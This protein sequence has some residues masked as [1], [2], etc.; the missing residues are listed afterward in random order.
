MPS[1]SPSPMH[2]AATNGA[3]DGLVHGDDMTRPQTPAGAMALTEYSA[4]PSPPPT[5]DRA[6]TRMRELLPPD[7]LLADGYPD[8]LRLIAGATSRVY[9][10]CRVTELTRAVNLSSRLGCNVLLKREDTQPVFSFKLRGAYNKMA[11]LDPAVSWKGVVCCSAG[12][13][14][15]GVAYSARKLKIP[16]TII[17]P[18]GTPAIKHR[19]V[20][21]LGG[22]VVLHGA[23]FDAAK[24]ECARRAKQDGLINIPP[25]DDPY[26][27]AGQGTIG[28]E[29]FSQVNMAKVEAIFCCC[30]GG[31]LIA[32]VGLYVKRMAPHVKVIGVE[33]H[34]ANALVQ[35]LRKDQRVLLKE[36]GL[37]ADG[38]AVKTM[39]EETF[40]IARDVVDEVIEVTTD[41]ICAAIK[42]MYDDTR[43]GLEPA[44]AM[45]IAGLKKYVASH[46]SSSYD[47]DRSLIAVTSGANMD[48][49]RLRFVAE[50]ASLGEGKEVLLAVSIAERPGAFA[51]LVD[52]IMPHAVTEFSYRW[53]TGDSAN[54]LIGLSL[55]APTPRRDDELRTLLERIRLDG[56]RVLDVSKDELAKSHVR[57]LV[58][59]RANVPNE[60]LYMFSFPERPGALERFL[61]ALRPRFNISV[62]HYRNYGGDIAKVLAGISCPEDDSAELSRF[63]DEVGYPFDECT[64]SD[65]FN[66]FLRA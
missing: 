49:D 29:L 32:G 23:D 65:V 56:M 50:R 35:S 22:H 54:M 57:Y 28:N 14:A 63:L 58:G 26:V 48:F 20:S 33:A 5:S 44:G 13:H 6:K 37:F 55:T 39:G 1:L 8:Y 21:R 36:V 31:G 30:G 24:E 45:S 11:H 17:M 7:L 62:F 66:M 52:A 19:N 43:S 40:R 9:E 10:A 46:P 41:Q 2:Q 61:L 51:K 53:A 3:S 16:A 59:G 4:N 12:N 34:D 60:R 42:D 15:Q 18:E 47:C 25:F 38:A 27:I 64:H